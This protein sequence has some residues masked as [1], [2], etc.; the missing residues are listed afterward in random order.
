[1]A[2]LAYPLWFA[3]FPMVYVAPDKRRNPFLRYHA[4]QGAALGL[5]GIVGLSLVRTVLGM[6]FRWLILFDVLLYPLLRC[7]EWAVLALVVY[8]AV[9]AALGR[10]APMPYI[11]GAVDALFADEAGSLKEEAKKS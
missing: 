5:F 1:M 10:R 2:A 3:V 7:A 9:M 8:G 6:F 11:T 4:Y